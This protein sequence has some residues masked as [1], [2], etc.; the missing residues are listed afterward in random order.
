MVAGVGHGECINEDHRQSLPRKFL[1]QIFL[2][3]GQYHAVN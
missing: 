1:L 2:Q 3:H